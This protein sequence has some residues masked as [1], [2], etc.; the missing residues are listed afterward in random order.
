MTPSTAGE[1]NN[2]VNTP[3]KLTKKALNDFIGWTTSR[4]NDYLGYGTKREAVDTAYHS[5]LNGFQTTA[6]YRRD[7]TRVEERNEDVKI[8]EIK[9]ASP[10]GENS[11]G[12][13]RG[14]GASNSYW[15]TTQSGDEYTINCETL[16]IEAKYSQRSIT[17][18]KPLNQ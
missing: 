6:W 4:Y 5:L 8:F 13:A 11:N 14:R 17:F 3:V 12:R 9:C 15:K 1:A 10:V 7:K 2:T 18:L 16:T